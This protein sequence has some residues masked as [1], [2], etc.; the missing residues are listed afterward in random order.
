MTT[1]FKCLTHTHSYLSATCS[2][3][4]SFVSQSFSFRMGL[5]GTLPW[6]YKLVPGMLGWLNTEGQSRVST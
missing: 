3:N 1:W 4:M 2:F 5:D 6:P